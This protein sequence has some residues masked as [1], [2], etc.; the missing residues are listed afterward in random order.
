[1]TDQHV[2]YA[3]EGGVATITMNRPEKKN[4]LT[5]QMYEDLVSA[6]KRADDDKAA[7]VILWR[8][9]GDL[10]T[11]G[12]DLKDFMSAPPAGFDSPVFQLLLT[13]VELETPVVAAVQGAAIGIGTTALLQC[14]LVYARDD[15]RFH[16]PFVNL[17][18]CPEGASSL[19]FPRIA[20]M[21]KAT[22]LLMFGE[23]FPASLGERMGFVNEIFSA[24][25]FEREVSERVQRLVKK[26]AASLRATKQLL[27][28]PQRA[29]IR[30]T[31]LREGRLF[32]ERLSAPE[33][34][35]AFSA[36]F[37]KRAPD[38]SSFD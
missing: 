27:R 19:L 31:M 13:L 23:P 38:F 9:V 5:V 6:F 1:M 14:D 4:A 21:Q 11:S 10:F 18:L 24:E 30:E 34:T 33:A 32:L 3:L 28:G 2:L 8:S 15:A 22:E 29:E 12:N 20:G 37:E 25:S 16:M 35:E 36:F 7:R 26:P 17:G